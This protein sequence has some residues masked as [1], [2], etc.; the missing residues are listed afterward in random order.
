LPLYDPAHQ[1]PLGF[2]SSLPI[3]WGEFVYVLVGNLSVRAPKLDQPP[4]GSALILC[5]QQL[6]FFR[7]LPWQRPAQQSG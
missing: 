5:G 1:H 3:L 6:Q 2:G 4:V 7:R